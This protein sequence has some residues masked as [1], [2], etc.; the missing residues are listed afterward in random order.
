M[1]DRIYKV[2]MHTL[3]NGKKYVGITKR[4]VNE[5]WKNG[6]GYKNNCRFYNAIRK[7]GWDNITHEI[8]FDNLTLKF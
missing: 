3:P 5:R 4:N 2:Y 6:N 1:E 7:Y 8:L